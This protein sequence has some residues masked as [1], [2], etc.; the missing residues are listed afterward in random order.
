MPHVL[1]RHEERRGD[2]PAAQSPLGGQLVTPVH[3]FGRVQLLATARPVGPDEVPRRRPHITVA[4]VSV[5]RTP[6]VYSLGD[7]QAA[8][9]NTFAATV[10]QAQG[11]IDAAIFELE[12][13]SSSAD[14]RL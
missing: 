8:F 7:A 1:S 4:F 5:Q 14:R 12:Q 9:R 6:G 11:S 2:R 10:P 3:Q 13:L